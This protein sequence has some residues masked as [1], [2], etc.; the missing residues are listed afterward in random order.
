MFEK[1]KS[2]DL[3]LVLGL[4][5]QL[6]FFLRFFIQWIATEKRKTS[7]IPVS[8][9]YL[10]IAGACGLLTYAIHIKDPVFIIGQSMGIFIYFR[11]LVF[12]HKKKRANS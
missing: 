3:W 5:A 12:I 9:W 6:L 7:V 10:S 4:V 1:L 11:N 2:P 8:F